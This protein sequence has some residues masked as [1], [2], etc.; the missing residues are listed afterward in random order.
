MKPS[1]AGKKAECER[2][3]FRYTAMIP[4]LTKQGFGMGFGSLSFPKK[5]T[6]G[7]G[8]VHGV[9]PSN[10]QKSEQNCTDGN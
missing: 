1:L 4:K 3:K 5:K 8:I 10:G 6:Q 9:A 7:F 2:N